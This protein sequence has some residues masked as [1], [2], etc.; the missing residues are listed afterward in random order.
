[1]LRCLCGDSEATPL[2]PR[3]WNRRAVTFTSKWNPK[4][5]KGN[6]PPPLEMD[7]EAWNSLM[8]SLNGGV[9]HSSVT[10]GVTCNFEAK[11]I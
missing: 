11:Q 4:L 7:M 2:P 3:P 8:Q 10:E 1:M 6:P 9:D 5:P